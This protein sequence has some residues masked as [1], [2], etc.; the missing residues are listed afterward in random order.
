MSKIVAERD[1]LKEL[2]QSEKMELTDQYQNLRTQYKEFKDLEQVKDNEKIKLTDEN[3]DLRKQVN[4]FKDAEQILENE[5]MELKKL[6][7]DLISQV[8][9]L[10]IQ[11]SRIEPKSNVAINIINENFRKTGHSQ[12]LLKDE[13]Q[14]MHDNNHDS[15]EHIKELLNTQAGIDV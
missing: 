11:S 10:K 13:N 14:N 9:G 8:N 1:R 3:R 2:W 4:E 15:A 12:I 6:N 7:R 5:K